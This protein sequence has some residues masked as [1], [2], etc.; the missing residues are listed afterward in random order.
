MADLLVR[1]VDDAL[2]QALL[3]WWRLTPTSRYG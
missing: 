3:L 2:V 1:D